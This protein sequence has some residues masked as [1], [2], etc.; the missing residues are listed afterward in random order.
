MKGRIIV[1]I[2]TLACFLGGLALRYMVYQ[3][4]SL[5]FLFFSAMMNFRSS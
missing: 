1:R 4:V 3:E 2:L 5:E